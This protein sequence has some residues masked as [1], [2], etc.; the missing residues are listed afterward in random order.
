MF[1]GG[2]TP[3]VKNDYFYFTIPQSF[4]SQNPVTFTQ[5]SLGRTDKSVPYNNFSIFI[6]QY[7][8][9]KGGLSPSLTSL[10]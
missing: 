5:G 1:V 8:L 10:I 9:K 7:S 6:I 3:A 2:L 4:A